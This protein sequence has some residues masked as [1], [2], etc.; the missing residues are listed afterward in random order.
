MDCLGERGG[1]TYHGPLCKRHYSRLVRRGDPTLGRAKRKD[2]GVPRTRVGGERYDKGDGY[3]KVYLPNHPN[4]NK[5]GYVLEHTLVMSEVL[6]R[7]LF[8]GESVH[9]KN[10]VRSDNSPDNLEL[11][12]KPPRKGVRVSDAIEDCI[13]FL[14]LYGY[15]TGKRT[16]E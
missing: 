12:T 3:I 11:W 15:E 13:K 6:G 8:K 16:C 9:H 14:A 10:G 1:A 2:S 5:H 4:A 7:P